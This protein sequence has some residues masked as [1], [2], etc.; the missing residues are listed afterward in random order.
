MSRAP[1][2][3]EEEE[4]MTYSESPKVSTQGGHD[5]GEADWNPNL[6]DGSDPTKQLEP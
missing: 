5:M 3:E 2:G 1:Q 6:S 4:D